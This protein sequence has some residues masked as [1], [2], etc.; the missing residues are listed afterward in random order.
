MHSVRQTMP[1][2]TAALPAHDDI[3]RWLYGK[4][5]RPRA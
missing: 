5:G 3:D 1:L 2:K 4:C